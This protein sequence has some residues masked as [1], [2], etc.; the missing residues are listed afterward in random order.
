MRHTLPAAGFSNGS[1]VARNPNPQNALTAKSSKHRIEVP[2]NFILDLKSESRNQLHSQ[3]NR[4]EQP[5]I[6]RI[7][8]ERPSGMEASFIEDRV[9]PTWHGFG[10]SGLNAGAGVGR[11]GDRDPSLECRFD[12]DDDDRTL[13]LLDRAVLTKHGSHQVTLC[14]TPPTS[15]PRSHPSCPRPVTGNG[16]FVGRGCAAWSQNGVAFRER[17]ARS[18]RASFRGS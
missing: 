18:Q 7:L 11:L 9:I 14:A 12:S 3:P 6:R 10:S 1:N 8:M 17:T 15:R 13:V 5:G 4:N 16:L 2:T